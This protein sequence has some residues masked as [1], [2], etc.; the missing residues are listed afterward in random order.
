MIPSDVFLNTVNS[1][2]ENTKFNLIAEV[3]PQLERK[4]RNYVQALVDHKA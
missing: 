2:H 4:E 1:I 3:Y